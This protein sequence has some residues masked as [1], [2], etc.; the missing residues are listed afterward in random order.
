MSKNINVIQVILNIFYIYT[1]SLTSLYFFFFNLVNHNDT[2][3]IEN[4]YSKIS[5]KIFQVLI[6][7]WLQIFLNYSV[8]ENIY[9][10]ML[11]SLKV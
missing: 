11:Y 1:L 3:M 9:W 8:E 7:H 5:L 2:Y 4:F 6:N 10:P